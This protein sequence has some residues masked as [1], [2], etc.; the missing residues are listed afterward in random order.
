LDAE[1]FE[2]SAVLDP[3]RLM[4]RVADRALAVIPSAQGALVGLREGSGLRF[5]CGSGTLS[6]QVGS[7]VGLHQSLAGL[8]VRTG[9]LLCSGD[10]AADPRADA[11]FSERIGVKSSIFV[12]VRRGH[13]ALGVVTVCSSLK[14]AFSPVDVS[15]LRQ[16]AE[17]LGIAVGFASDLAGARDKLAEANP[18]PSPRAAEAGRGAL[19]GGG[20][21]LLSLLRPESIAWMEAKARI[22][23]VLDEPRRLSMVFQPIV[24]VEQGRAVSFEALARFAAE[25]L[26]PPDEW[27]NEANAAGLGVE[28]EMLAV[29]TALASLPLLPAGVAMTVNVGPETLSGEPLLALLAGVEPGKVVLELTEHTGVDDYSQ[30]RST[31]QAL[32]K[33]GV[34]L[35]VD[36]TGAGISSLAHI[37]KLAPDYIKLDRELV[38]GIDIDP[39]RRALASSLLSFSAE[40]GATVIA[41]GVETRDELEVLRQ[42]GVRYVQGYYFGRPSEIG[43]SSWAQL[44]AGAGPS[45]AEGPH[46]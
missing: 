1:D 33:M 16:L 32:G 27:F 37:L 15:L 19:S 44:P 24:D 13:E 42:A 40:T 12:P 10:L 4:Q 5:V 31:V 14:R 41:E 23:R 28:L 26:R 2:I 22:Q 18:D 39:V 6:G 3:E 45:S 11:V 17:L 46:G 35:A 43:P 30:L 21:F 8:A 38:R 36:D 34:R 29:S 7:T 20:R 25:P 9:K